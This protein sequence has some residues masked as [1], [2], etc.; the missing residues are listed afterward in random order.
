V[1]EVQKERRLASSHLPKREAGDFLVRGLRLGQATQE[2]AGERNVSRVEQ[3][4]GDSG[5]ASIEDR[6]LDWQCP[7]T[8]EAEINQ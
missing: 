3:H 5:N 4:S 2:E 1:V 6:V 8:P 7:L